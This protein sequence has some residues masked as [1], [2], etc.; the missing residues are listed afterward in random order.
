MCHDW[1]QEYTECH[2]VSRNIIHCPTYHKQQGSAKGFFGRLFH[3]SVKNKK[4]CGR[5]IPHYAESKPFCPECIVRIDQLRARHVGDGALKVYRPDLDNDFRRPFKDYREKR[6]H[7]IVMS[8]GKEIRGV[9]YG[10]ERKDHVI[11]ETHSVWVP[12]L[13]H[14]PEMLARRDI[15]KN[16]QATKAMAPVSSSRPNKP[17]PTPKYHPRKPVK[18][19]SKPQVHKQNP[20]KSHDHNRHTPEGKTPASSRSRPSRRPVEPAPTHRYQYHREV[21]GHGQAIPPAP[22]TPPKP[23]PRPP[24]SRRGSDSW[25]Q[26]RLYVATNKP[27][28]PIPRSGEPPRSAPPQEPPTLRRKR[29]QVHKICPPR[30]PPAPVPLPMYQ[31]Y[32]NAFRVAADNPGYDA[33]MIAQAQRPPPKKKLGHFGEE[34]RGSHLRRMIGMEPGSPDSDVSE[35]SFMCVESKQL[36]LDQGQQHARHR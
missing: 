15:S 7:A 25:P 30:P 17:L 5:L 18:E 31:E 24:I 4:H 35:A 11:I 16:S 10:Q 2:H 12:E 36:T 6:K 32:L 13:Y 22:E 33:E 27:L 3:G 34:W 9:R 20:K 8:S 14:H 21:P 1:S 23:R 19:E 28:P 26:Q 29:G